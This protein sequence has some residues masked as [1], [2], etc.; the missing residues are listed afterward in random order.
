[1]NLLTDANLKNITLKWSVVASAAAADYCKIQYAYLFD[2]QAI[3]YVPSKL[4][5]PMI[6]TNA[7]ETER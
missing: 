6:Q 2:G 7:M 1:M 5:R 4:A 3:R